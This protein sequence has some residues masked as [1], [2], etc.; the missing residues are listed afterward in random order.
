MLKFYLDVGSVKVPKWRESS[1]QT[2][3]AVRYP[4]ALQDRW[5]N[6]NFLTETL[7]QRQNKYSLLR[8]QTT[9][10]CGRVCKDK[11]RNTLK[12]CA[13][14]MWWPSSIVCC[15]FSFSWRENQKARRVCPLLPRGER[16]NRS[17]LANDS[18]GRFVVLAS[19]AR[20]VQSHLL[21][22]QQI[23]HIQAE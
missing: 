7:E 3:G 14:R 2:L 21:L 13:L 5:G 22:L 19:A 16:G 12:I 18:P 8:S 1:W 6:P 17:T 4:Q 11:S 20:P 10:V 15:L 23:K 9:A